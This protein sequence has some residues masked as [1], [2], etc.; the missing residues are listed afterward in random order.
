M[1]ESSDSTLPTL[2]LPLK[3]LHL[4]DA[5]SWFP[6]AWG[7]WAS[8]AAIIV[9]ILA[10]VLLIRWNKKKQA[11]KKTALRLL[12]PSH[13]AVKPSAAIE[14]VRQAAL[15]YF[16]REQVAQLT[17][18]EWYAF[19]DSQLTDPLFQPNEHQWQAALYQKDAVENPEELVEHCY[20]WVNDA[21]P[22]KKGRAKLG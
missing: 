6:L 22:P 16:P 7:W 1:K 19:L 20:Q 21:L 9:A 3:A 15:C 11:P 18:K 13:T 5:P 17:G 14:L 2:E 12:K 8:F 10:V 4:P